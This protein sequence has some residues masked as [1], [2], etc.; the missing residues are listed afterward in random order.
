MTKDKN[1]KTWFDRHYRA[2]VYLLLILL[3]NLAVVDYIY[4]PEHFRLQETNPWN[5]ENPLGTKLQ[6]NWTLFTTTTCPYCANQK[7]ILHSNQINVTLIDCD[8][9]ERNLNLCKEYNITMVPTWL[10]MNTGERIVGVQTIED[11][12]KLI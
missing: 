11:L 7:Q 3:V 10:N 6:N 12:K 1:G 8:I 2:I 9:S 4:H 5:E